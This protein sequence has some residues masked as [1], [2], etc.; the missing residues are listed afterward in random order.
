MNMSHAQ[1]DLASLVLRINQLEERQDTV[2]K[3]AVRVKRQLDRLTE[4]FNTRPELQQIESLHGA[5]AQL[6]KELVAWH[7]QHDQSHSLSETFSRLESL[8]QQDCDTLDD[9]REP[10]NGFV[11]LTEAESNR[12]PESQQLTISAKEFLR[13]Y[14]EAKRDF[15]EVNLARVNLSGKFLGYNLNLTKANLTEAKLGKASLRE[16]NLHS[17]KSLTLALQVAPAC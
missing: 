8:D 12:S 5:I 1:P 6:S 16:V 14:N 10:A 17:A 9:E 15:R 11:N 7:Q 4:Q 3:Y 2:A 13:Q